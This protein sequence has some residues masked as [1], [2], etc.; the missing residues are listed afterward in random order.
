L[1]RILFSFCNFISRFKQR[2][3][4]LKHFTKKL[5]TLCLF[6]LSIKQINF[7]G[8]YCLFCFCFSSAFNKVSFI[9]LL[10][11][12]FIFMIVT[13]GG[14]V[15]WTNRKRALYGRKPNVF[16][17]LLLYM[18]MCWLVQ[19]CQSNFWRK[20]YCFLLVL[21]FSGQTFEKKIFSVYFIWFSFVF[22]LGNL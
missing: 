1:K 22:S 19:V 9:V 16:M 12:P 6:L 11:I 4:L 14:Y 17:S 18:W 5:I 10:A 21:D 15:E 8:H 13:V 20:E 3:S 7:D 2:L